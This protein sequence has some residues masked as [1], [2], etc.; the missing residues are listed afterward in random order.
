MFFLSV[1]LHVPAATQPFTAFSSELEYLMDIYS[2]YSYFSPVFILGDFN[3]KIAGPR[4]VPDRRSELVKRL[5]DTSHSIS[6]PTQNFAKGFVCT[7]QSYVNG[8]KTAI[9]HIVTCCENLKVVDSVI[10]PHDDLCYVSGHK[11]I[12]CSLEIV[13][14]VTVRDEVLEN[15]K[16]HKG[17]WKKALETNSVSDNA[18]ALSQFSWSIKVPTSPVSGEDIGNYYKTIND[19]IIRSDKEI[20]P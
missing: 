5:V 16:F 20:L 4:Y 12:F 2:A 6:L 10:V 3:C 19:A 15:S 14:I 1:Y 17:S 11:P 13:N 18:F 8:S 7:F 9:D